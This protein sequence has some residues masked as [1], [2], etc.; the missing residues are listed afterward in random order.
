MFSM[1]KVN[2]N[3]FQ[4]LTK[5]SNSN[6]LI[7]I[8]ISALCATVPLDLTQLIF[9]VLGAVCYY[10]VQTLQSSIVV[11]AGQKPSK[12]DKVAEPREVKKR[13]APRKPEANPAD[14]AAQ[15]PCVPILPPSFKGESLD[16]E[17]KELISQIMPTVQSQRGVDR[18]AEAIRVML[19]SSLPE[20]EVTGFASSDLSRG[21]A[22]G[23][24]V[25]DVDIVIQVRPDRVAT[26]LPSKNVSTEPRMLQ[27]WALRICADRLVSGGFKFRRS[28]FRGNEP[29]MTLLV[30]SEL[31]IFETAVPIDISVN[32]LTP[33]HSAA[34]IS[35]CGN[36]NLQS[37][38]LILLIRRWAKDRG[39]CHAPKGH[40]SPYI[41]SLLVVYYLQVREEPLLP[42]VEDFQA[43]KDLLPE[44]NVSA[45]RNTWQRPKATTGSEL[46]KG[47]MQF[48]KNFPWKSEGICVL[49]GTKGPLPLSLPIHI[50]EHE[51][52]KTTECGP[53]IQDPFAPKTNL[54]NGMTGWSFQ[55]MK[56]E[57]ARAASLLEQDAPSLSKLLEPWSPPEEAPES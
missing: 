11:P 17:V 9:A 24:A 1:S 57:V 30:P 2:V 40:L 48:Y 22:N 26:K 43:I 33:L 37:K 36:L 42:P 54:G 53:N 31:K 35:E 28:G 15:P 3:L 7:L 46:L 38:E 27:K 14:L 19:A 29:K 56:E 52:K 18:L 16:D 12:G 55:R 4:G 45:G 44:R 20:V 8:V 25:P 47:F 10:L 21:R 34:L 6:L 23:V 49:K 39:I 32:A 50:I 5:T 41:W 13:R 51:D